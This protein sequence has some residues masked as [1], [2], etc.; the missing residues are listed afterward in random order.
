[1]HPS[2]EDLHIFSIGEPSP[3]LIQRVEEHIHDCDQC[4]LTVV[5]LVRES[6]PSS[7][8][9]AAKNGSG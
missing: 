7:R 3:E 4:S 5:R 2:D 8:V 6:M 9:D 1:M